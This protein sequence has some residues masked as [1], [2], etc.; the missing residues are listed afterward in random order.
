M[1]GAI[2][3]LGRAIGA[4]AD[5]AAIGMPG[6]R[7]DEAAG[8]IAEATRDT[9]MPVTSAAMRALLDDAYAGRRPTTPASILSR[10]TPG[11]IAP[12]ITA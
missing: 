7:L 12:P 8:L 9:A 11:P 1:A 3:D 6:D 10:A 4:P 2:Y 5:L